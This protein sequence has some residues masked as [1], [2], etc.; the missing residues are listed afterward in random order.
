I[1]AQ[2]EEEQQSLSSVLEL[3]F[4]FSERKQNKRLMEE[5]S[6]FLCK[7]DSQATIELLKPNAVQGDNTFLLV[8]HILEN[9]CCYSWYKGGRE[10]VYLS[11]SLLLYNDNQK[12]IEFYILRTLN[13]Q[14]EIQ[15]TQMYLHI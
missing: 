1:S 9:I 12:D 3:R 14:F 6:V 11:G 2:K 13:T 10:T 7:W 5:S 4:F 15:E 8:H